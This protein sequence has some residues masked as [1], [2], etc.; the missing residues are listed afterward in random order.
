MGGSNWNEDDGGGPDSFAPD[1][2]GADLLAGAENVNQIDDLLESPP[3]PE[4]SHVSPPST[5]T[6]GDSARK[7]PDVFR[8]EDSDPYFYLLHKLEDRVNPNFVKGT[9]GSQVGPQTSHALRLHQI[10]VASAPYLQG[11]KKQEREEFPVL[12]VDESADS[13]ACLVPGSESDYESCDD[14]SSDDLGSSEFD[15]GAAA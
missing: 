6:Q 15:V 9:K 7:Y 3:A 11:R 8:F 12:A 1:D 14:G 13:D 4:V 10:Y 5:P 2:D